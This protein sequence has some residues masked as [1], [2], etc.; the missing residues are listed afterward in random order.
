MNKTETPFHPSSF[1]LPPSSFLCH[2]LVEQSGVLATLTSWRTLV[3]IQPRLLQ[4][5]GIP[6][7]GVSKEV[8]NGPGRRFLTPDS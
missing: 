5:P 7:S 3:Q 4:E 1:I 2:S 8:S 6:E